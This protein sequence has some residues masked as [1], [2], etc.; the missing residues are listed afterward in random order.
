[1]SVRITGHTAHVETEFQVID[2]YETE[3]LGTMLFLDGHVQL[4]TIDERSYHEALV[5]IPLL[6][7]PSPARALV[8]GGGDGG[9]IREL[10]RHSELQSI[11]MV[12]IDPGVIEAC[13]Q[14]LPSI[15]NGAFDDPR[16]NL[17]V[18]DAFGFAK[19]S[20]A[21][22]D[23]IVMDITD[24]YEDEEGELSERL[25]TDEFHLDCKKMLAP[26]GVLVTQADNHVFCPYSMQGILETM[27]NLFEKTGAYQALVPSFGG[28]SGF[29]WASKGTEVS[30]NKIDTAR[31]AKL[32][33]SSLNNT[34]LDLAFTQLEFA[35][36]TPLGRVK[37]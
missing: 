7:V 31:L 33:L 1:M 3:A 23:L 5:H 18:E 6:C 29:V 19:R 27:G 14:L 20:E 4:S 28:Y 26:G 37:A 9:V 35:K 36:G 11:D 12:E 13:R 32:N 24:V 2:I 25:F 21:Q 22:Y 10:C 34:T 8:V 17:F 16:V 15:S 30:R